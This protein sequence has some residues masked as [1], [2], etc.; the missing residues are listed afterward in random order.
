[1][2]A[3]TGDRT[4]DK[5]FSQRYGPWALIAGGS[6]GIGLGFAEELAGRGVNLILLARR[7]EGLEQARNSLLS[8]HDIAVHTHPVDLTAE[9]LGQQVDL[10]VGERE[11]GLLVYNAGAAH[12]ASLFLDAPLEKARRLIDLNCHGPAVLCHRLGGAMRARGRGGIILMSSMSGFAGSAYTA[13]YSA[14]KSF[15][16]ILAEALWAEL[17][18]FGVDVLGLVAGATET[19]SMVRSGVDFSDFPPMEPN[20]VATEGLRQLPHGPLHIVGERNRS[21]VHHLRGD[22]AVAVERLSTGAAR[23]YG[24][25]FPIPGN[26]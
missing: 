23:M 9:D 5:A 6:D 12:G 15:D 1:M 21:I 16:M 19:P 18:P 20:E 24:K 10:A 26:R 8:R 11:V 2:P 17:R 13:V 7:P 3:G 4:L 25:A 14:S 22:R